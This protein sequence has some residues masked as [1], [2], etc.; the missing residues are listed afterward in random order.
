MCC[1][2]Q[3][4]AR[5]RRLR[6]A[7]RSG[8][9]GAHAEPRSPVP[10]P[11]CLL[12]TPEAVISF[13]GTNEIRPRLLPDAEDDGIRLVRVGMILLRAPGGG[14]APLIR[15]VQTHEFLR[16][17]V[18]LSWVEDNPLR[19]DHPRATASNSAKRAADRA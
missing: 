13:A 10:S 19:S 17:D 16:Q 15:A 14:T 6:H 7:V 3:C 18:T 4:A 5:T 9:T 11:A 1:T 2:S 8:D 12:Q